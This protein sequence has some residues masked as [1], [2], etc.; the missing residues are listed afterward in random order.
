LVID[1]LYA[2]EALATEARFETGDFKS[3]NEYIE[4][5]APDENGAQPDG[6]V[7]GVFAESSQGYYQHKDNEY[8]N[9]DPDNQNSTN[10]ANSTSDTNAEES[11]DKDVN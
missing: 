4:I 6:T 7:R 9:L 10:N 8:W 3:D 5:A 11:E 2:P 1:N